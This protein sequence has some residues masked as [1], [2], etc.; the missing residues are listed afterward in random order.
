LFETND[1]DPTKLLKD[2]LFLIQTLM[3]KITVPGTQIDVFKVS[4]KNFINKT[5]YLGYMFEKALREITAKN[6]NFTKGDEAILRERYTKSRGTVVSCAKYTH[7]DTKRETARASF[8]RDDI[9]RDPS[10][11][12]CQ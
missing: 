3:R 5:C 7:R 2:L 8:T 10:I 4:F 12:R 11:F 6:N 1:V 9:S